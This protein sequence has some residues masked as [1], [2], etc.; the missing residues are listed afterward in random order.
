MRRNDG[1]GAFSWRVSQ[2]LLIG[3]FSASTVLPGKWR[4]RHSRLVRRM[5]KALTKPGNAPVRNMMRNA[6]HY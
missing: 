3:I 1:R 2:F 6:T 4:R 5:P